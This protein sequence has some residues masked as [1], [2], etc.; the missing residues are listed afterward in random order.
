MYR[1]GP[2]DCSLSP[3]ANGGREVPIISLMMLRTS[4][5][6]LGQWEWKKL[7]RHLSKCVIGR[8]FPN[9]FQRLTFKFYKMA[10]V[11]ILFVMSQAQLDLNTAPT[12]S[13]T[14]QLCSSGDSEDNCR[15]FKDPQF[16]KLNT[17]NY[18][19]T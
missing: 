15:N 12:H 10:I 9:T 5:V 4:D 3:K 2:N 16:L 13:G 18:T 19:N 14:L 7:K 8:E 6:I 11:F 1:I 17:K